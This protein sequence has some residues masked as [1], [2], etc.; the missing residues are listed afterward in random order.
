MLCSSIASYRIVNDPQVKY[1][2]TLFFARSWVT[3]YNI[4]MRLTFNEK[5]GQ[6]I[7][8]QDYLHM[9]GN[10]RIGLVYY[11]HARIM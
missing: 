7:M 4:K 8:L 2:E 1:N 9:E 6:P 5:Q 11:T 3:S 10:Y